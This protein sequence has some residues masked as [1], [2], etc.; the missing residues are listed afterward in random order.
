LSRL[1]DQFAPLAAKRGLKLKVRLCSR[2]PY[3][4]YSDVSILSQIIGNLIDNAIKYTE[5]GWIVIGAVR[6]SGDRLKLHVRD[7]GIGIADNL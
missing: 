7:N 5:G 1:E 2:P 3:T 4:I 6:I